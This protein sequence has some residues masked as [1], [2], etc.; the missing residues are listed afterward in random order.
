MLQR[1]F[2]AA[3]ALVLAACSE[4]APTPTNTSIVA[5]HERALGSFPMPVWQVAF[6]PDGRLL[7]G[8][9]A[10]GSI[11][12]WRWPEGVIARTLEHPGGA[13]GIAFSPDGRHL[14][15]SGYDRTLR[16]WNLERGQVERTLE[17]HGGT[18][19]S[20]AFSPD[21]RLLASG[22]EDKTV[23][24]WSMA[25][26]K[27]L[28]T[29]AA[30]ERNVWSV[31]FGPEGKWLASGSFDNTAKVWSV[32]AGDLLGKLAAHTEAVVEVAASPDGRWIATGGDDSVVRLWR[33][34]ADKARAVPVVLKV[35][36]H[37]YGVTFSGD[38]RYVA[39]G[40]REKGALGTMI[41][42]FAGRLAMRRDPTVHVWRI[43][44]GAL[45]LAL[46]EPAD[47]VHSVAFSPDGVWL[48]ASGADKA[49]HVWRIAR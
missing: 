38:S 18:V 19:W 31:R 6:S 48:A 27:L 44:D 32:P 45:L 15:S 4:R 12:L 16:L 33:I 9:S 34:E 10:D 29:I 30:H 13:T 21:G 17:G 3:A 39:S 37:V 35:P 22:G 47:D 41:K 14:A 11:S 1:A 36:Q 26:G 8:A 49:V 7:A 28:R 23:K 42:H 46:S 5:K 43:E 20:V 2:V 40:S 24:L 25:D